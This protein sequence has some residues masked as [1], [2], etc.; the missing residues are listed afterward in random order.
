MEIQ[1]HFLDCLNFESFL[2]VLKLLKYFV[3]LKHV[4][5]GWSVSLGILLLALALYYWI[6][7]VSSGASVNNVL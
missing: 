5:Y 6:C 3:C 4:C 2:V 1:S 7:E